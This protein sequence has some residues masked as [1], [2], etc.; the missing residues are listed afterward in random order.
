MSITKFTGSFLPC[1]QPLQTRSFGTLHPLA[2]D[3]GLH[4]ISLNSPPPQPMLLQL[5][6]QLTLWLNGSQSLYLDQLAWTA[7]QTATWIPLSILLFYLI[8]RNNDLPGI[9]GTLLALGLCILLADQM[10]STVFKPWVGRFRPTNDPSLM[11]AVDVVNGYRGGKFGFFSSHAANTMAIAT[12]LSLLVRQKSLSLWLYSWALLNCW[13]RVYLGV[14]YI[15]D[16]LTGTLWGLF[17]GWVV[18]KLWLRYCPGVS[19]R[20]ERNALRMQFTAGGYSL[21][22]VHLLIAGIALSYLFIALRSLF[23]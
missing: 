23:V 11:Y 18:F 6:Q 15:G 5:D 8:I 9:G 7:T 19:L 10:A 1:K 4:S 20:R 3:N 17:V 22:S 13:T 16:L 21:G 2:T 12:F 14:H